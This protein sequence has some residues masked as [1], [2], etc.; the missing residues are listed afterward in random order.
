MNCPLYGVCPYL[1][2]SVM[3]GFT[4]RVECSVDEHCVVKHGVN[5]HE[6]WCKQTV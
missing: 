2:G 3:R 5:K 1:G 4:V 6:A